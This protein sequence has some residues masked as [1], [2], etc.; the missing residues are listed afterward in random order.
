MSRQEEA[1]FLQ[2]QERAL[3]YMV[4]AFRAKAGNRMPDDTEDLLQEARLALLARLR[5]A[6]T[7]DEARRYR[8]NIHRAMFNHVRRMAAI[9]ISDRQFTARIRSVFIFSVDE[10]LADLSQPGFEN[11]SNARIDTERFMD[12]LTP[13]EREIVRLKSLGYTQKQI[14]E[15]LVHG[16]ESR[17]SRALGRIR[18]KYEVDSHDE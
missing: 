8:L 17:V 4:L 18:A 9:R 12:S 11:E 15:R 16:S 14:A 10:S 13:L 5:S 3:E 7:M 6:A 1:A 2:S